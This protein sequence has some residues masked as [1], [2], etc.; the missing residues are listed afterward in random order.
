MHVVILGAGRLGTMVALQLSEKGY[1][2]LLVDANEGKF[3]SLPPKTTIERKSG[4]I[5]HEEIMR[6][7]FSEIPDVFVAV[8]GRDNINLMAA[9][10]VRMRYRVP[11][12]IARVFDPRLADVYRGFGLE[13]ICPTNFAVA[14]IVR[15]VG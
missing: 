7:V 8:T 6:D 3:R 4:D 9:Q 12:I 2:V 14:E 1:R 15:T 10:V 13:M 11:R 5:F